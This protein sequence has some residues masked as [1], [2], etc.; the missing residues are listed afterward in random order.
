[1]VHL[2]RTRF[3]VKVIRTNPVFSYLRMSRATFYQL[4]VQNGPS[5]SL[6]VRMGKNLCHQK[7]NWQQ[8]HLH[9]V[10]RLRISGDISPLLLLVPL[11]V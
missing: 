2:I 7:K 11:R 9:L 5:L 4:S 8:Q 10:V 1:V 6:K 3:D